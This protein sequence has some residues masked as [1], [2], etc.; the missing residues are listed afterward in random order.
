M[1]TEAD[2]V[3]HITDARKARTVLGLPVPRV[4]SWSGT[5]SSAVESAYILMEHAQGTQLGEVWQDTEVDEKQA[6]IDDI[7]AAEK[8]MSSVSFTW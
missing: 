6:V 1:Y 3:H 7:V 4:L 8:K 5:D 2:F